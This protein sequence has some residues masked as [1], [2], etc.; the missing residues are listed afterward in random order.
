MIKGLN[1]LGVRNNWGCSLNEQKRYWLD[2]AFK[3]CNYKFNSVKLTYEQF[4]DVISKD[5]YTLDEL[6]FSNNGLSKFLKRTFPDRIS[7]TGSDK[8]CKFLLGKINKKQCSKCKTIL[9]YNDFY[10]SN[11]MKDGYSSQCKNCSDS[12]RIKNP[13]LYNSYIAQRRAAKKHRTVRWD[14]KGIKEFYINCPEGFQVDHIIPLQ[15]NLVCGLHVLS[16][17]QYLTIQENLQK[18]NKY[19][20]W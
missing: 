1:L 14:Q 6:G 10:L 11:S 13:N 20:G 8:I 12:Y 2:K 17:L 3:T 9:N 19:N 7:K 16:N 18:G 15:G 5:N 4:L